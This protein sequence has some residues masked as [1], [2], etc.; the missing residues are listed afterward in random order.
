MPADEMQSV[1]EAEKDRTFEWI[2]KL[3][4][5]SISLGERMRWHTHA[6]GSAARNE[7]VPILVEFGLPFIAFLR[8]TR[9]SWFMFWKTTADQYEN[10]FV[11]LFPTPHHLES[12]AGG[13]RY[14]PYVTF[15]DGKHS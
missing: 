15:V 8:P 5:T 13:L 9:L 12:F 6:K 3:N 2:S 1:V 10:F 4:V 14:V 11:A 7:Q